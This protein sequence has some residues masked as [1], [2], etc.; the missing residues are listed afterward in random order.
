MAIQLK[1][2]LV[3]L[4]NREAASLIAHWVIEAAQATAAG[5]QAT[6]G[7]KRIKIKALANARA[8]GMPLTVSHTEWIESLKARNE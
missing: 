2:G 4:N 5:L 3:K 7:C 1:S 6:A 8:Q